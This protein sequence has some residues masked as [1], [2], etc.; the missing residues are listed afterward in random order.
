MRKNRLNFAFDC[1]VDPSAICKETKSAARFICEVNSYISS[2]GKPFATVL[3]TA[4]NSTVFCHT[5]SFSN[6]NTTLSAY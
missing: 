4:D 1:P 2:F 5:I 6:L 3:T